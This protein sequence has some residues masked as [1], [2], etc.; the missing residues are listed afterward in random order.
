VTVA[1]AMTSIG[2][3]APGS[4]TV[5]AFTAMLQP[6]EEEADA[7]PVIDEYG[8]LAGLLTTEAISAVEPALR[9]QLRIDQLAYGLDR[10]TIVDHRQALL[11]ALQRLDATDLGRG[12][13]VDSAGTVI[14]LIDSSALARTIAR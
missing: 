14:G 9:N 7:F 1:D 13:V 3:T 10:L 11:P 5:A 2:T 4:A 6:D 8:E 12:I